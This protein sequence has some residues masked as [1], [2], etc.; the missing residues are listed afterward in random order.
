M[1]SEP[2]WAVFYEQDMKTTLSLL[3]QE[4]RLTREK[5]ERFNSMPRPTE[6]PKKNQKNNRRVDLD[7]LTE[8]CNA[9]SLMLYSQSSYNFT[10]DLTY[11]LDEVSKQ[12]GEFNTKIQPYEQRLS[13]MQAGE[14]RYN[15]LV[16]TL[17]NMPDNPEYNAVRD[18]CVVIAEQLA[19]IY[20]Q[21]LKRLETDEI[22]Y[23]GLKQQLDDA[24]EYAQKSYESVQQRI[25]LKGQPSLW[26][27]LQR[28]EFYF[29]RL[30]QEITEKYGSTDVSDI[31]SA[32]IW[33]GS[34]VLLFGLM[35]LIALV[36]SFLFA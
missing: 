7:E 25:F 34:A 15:R 14:D 18:S 23:Q 31:T 6:K 35:A 9:L 8:Q 20:S 3:L 19:G 12:Y 11:A 16:K 36:C 10:F 26:T 33:S 28:H 22:R 17:K 30:R 24:Y 21:S 13:M 5:F 4:L 29:Q 32:R 1:I 27:M 2:A